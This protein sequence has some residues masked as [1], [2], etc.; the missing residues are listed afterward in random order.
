MNSNESPVNSGNVLESRIHAAR[1]LVVDDNPDQLDL[2]EI[3]LRKQGYPQVTLTD[4][5]T[6]VAP[7]YAAK[8][9][10]L[11]LL[12]M[13]MPVMNGVQVMQQ[14]KQVLNGAFMPVIV[15][16][17]HEG[18]AVR[19]QALQEGARDY[20][21]KPFVEAEFAHRIHN[22]LEVHMLYK[23][24]E[25]QNEILELK[26]AERTRELKETQTDILRRLAKA[27]EFR[28]SDTGNHVTRVSHSCRVLAQAAGV[29]AH[30][31]EMIYMAS[32]LHDI[33]KIGVP[34]HI[35]L[36]KGRLTDEEMVIMRLHVQFGAEMLGNHPAPL[37]QVAC[38]IAQNHHEKWDGSGYP[39]ALAGDAIP[40]EARIVAIC[41]VFDAL[42]SIRPYKV[43]WTVEGAVGH[44][45]ANSG[46]HFD[47]NLIE[48]FVKILPEIE[49]IR[50]RFSDATDARL[51]A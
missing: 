39:C 17:A 31:T 32:P 50:A 41:D 22:H 49:A 34:D 18:A 33:G 3:M 12:D 14:L 9:Y 46:S 21:A 24:R 26:V 38:S 47:P 23:E 45:Q 4:D 36:K 11:I 25:Q 7:A 8:P 28:D 10:D 19:L 5:P 48:L 42:T 2:M 15:L 44:L 27:G 16:T 6:S 30:L 35:L 40:I 51:V 43:A 20:L 37:L 1:I 13:E 29:N